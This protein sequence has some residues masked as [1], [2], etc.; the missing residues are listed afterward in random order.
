MGRCSISAFP[1]DKPKSGRTASG[2]TMPLGVRLAGL[3]PC[4]FRRMERTS[5]Q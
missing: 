2:Q 4:L 1:H 3:L 5:V